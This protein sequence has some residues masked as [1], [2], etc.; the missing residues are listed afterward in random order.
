[1][2]ILVSYRGIPESRGWATGDFVVEAFKQLGHN[3]DV[4]GNY[5]GTVD[6]LQNK[7]N[8]FDKEY[9][10]FLFMECGDPEPF[11][12]ELRIVNA[13]IKASWF[14]D[15]ALYV[16]YWRHQV[17]TVGTSPNF[18]G[19]ANLVSEIQNG[20]YL[21]YAASH[22]HYRK[23]NTEKDID[24]L[25]IGSDRPERRILL[26]SIKSIFPSKR[27]EL[28]SGVYRDDYINYLSR[29]KFVVNDIAGGGKGLIPMR[30]FEVIMAGST[31]ITPRGDGVSDLGIPC[32]EY[33]SIDQ[34]VDFVDELPAAQD[35]V[36]KNHTYVNRCE[37][38]I[39]HVNKFLE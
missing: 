31:L 13:K 17:F 4:Y 35:F 11:Y 37:K 30:P 28:V 22:K 34:L 26:D 10:L 25:I 24:Y 23:L 5:Y 18:I 3:V 9:D 7:L 2:K 29:A 32:Y 14:F 8:P 1:M 39:S 15:S 27:V 21:P 20:I 6:K 19:N 16:D 38:I 36:I 33:D 12:K